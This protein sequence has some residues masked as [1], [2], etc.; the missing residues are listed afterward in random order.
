MTI[1][2]LQSHQ[3]S[4]QQEKSHFGPKGNIHQNMKSP[5]IALA[6]YSCVLG[7]LVACKTLDDMYR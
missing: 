1:S 2:Y 6:K 3:N 7:G 4:H 5:T